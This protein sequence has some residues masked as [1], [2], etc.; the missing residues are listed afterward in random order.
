MTLFAFR[1]YAAPKTA[2][3]NLLGAGRPIAMALMDK[4]LNIGLWII[5]V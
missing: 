5:C 3:G 4:A 2:S 1:S